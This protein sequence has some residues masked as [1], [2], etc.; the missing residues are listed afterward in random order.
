M[1]CIKY[2]KMN[3]YT[4][5]IK[6]YVVFIFIFAAFTDLSAQGIMNN[7]AYLVISPSTTLTISNTNGHYSNLSG[8]TTVVNGSLYLQGNFTNNAT[9][10]STS[11]TV[12]LNGSAVQTIGGST[13]P[14]TFYNL[15]LNNSGDSVVIGISNARVNN[16]LTLNSSKIFI[17]TNEITLGSSA[18]SPGTLDYTA[19]RFY[20]STGKFTR[21]FGTSSIAIGNVAGLFPMGS[22][23]YYHPFWFGSAAAL[24]SG[25]TISVNHNPSIDGNNT[26]TPYIDASWGSG[27]TVV[28]ISK[29]AWN[30]STANSFALN[31]VNGRIRFGGYGFLP[32]DQNDVNASLAL[33]TSGTYGAPT[34]VTA[35]YFEVNR[36]SIDDT[37]LGK[38][39]YIGTRDKNNSP[40]PVDLL[41]FEATCKN[42]KVLISWITASESN[43]SHF[44]LYRST[45][46]VVWKEIGSIQGAGNSNQ[47]LHYAYYDQSFN[48]T[49]VYYRL[50]Q[51]DFNGNVKEFP[52]IYVNCS[53]SDL[54]VNIFPN[55]FFEE[56]TLNFSGFRE[57]DA[58]VFIFDL[59]GKQIAEY[60]LTGITKEYQT[61]LNLENLATGIYF[62]DVRIP[63]FN[64]NFKI[65][66]N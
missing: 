10:T 38:T 9:F 5:N 3:K 61:T 25:G 55:P 48:N 32:F 58:S 51:T 37:N 29:A 18:A 63:D 6:I 49:P 27:T 33:G 15:S 21:W 19:G 43:N 42:D 14:T 39:W 57:S 50:S 35:T 1:L 52:D 22:K 17:N 24:T 65:I 36:T 46:L 13:S 53:N 60:K 59:L 12:V 16:Q 11:G 26:I 30:V 45:D 7:G 8:S 56:I 44:T 40:L 28:A 47:T 54:Q 2:I 64:R 31:G 23:S 4:S 62:I 66:K 20:G 34:N 41:S